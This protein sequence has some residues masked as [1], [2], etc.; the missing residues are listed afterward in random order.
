[1]GTHR[2]SRREPPLLIDPAALAALR[3]GEERQRI[4]AELHERCLAWARR[5][6]RRLSPVDHREIVAEALADALPVIL[7][8][9]ADAAAVDRAIRTSLR[10]S[11]SSLLRARG[12][13]AGPGDGPAE[14]ERDF[15]QI[16]AR[17][18]MEHLVD[19]TRA[20][21]GFISIALDLLCDRDHDLL[22]AGYK[23]TE[24]G[25]RLRGA[26]PPA[27]PDA[28]ALAAATRLALRHFSHNLEAVYVAGRS[29]LAMDPALLDEALRLVRGEA[30]SA[31]GL[32]QALPG[33]T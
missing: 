21:G 28:E 3:G 29:A 2:R 9:D 11:K 16:T 25:L 12:Q 27:F 30:T 15:N 33:R 19:V 1:M 22:I 5:S 32:I 14:L 6:G 18:E 13:R 23:L 24:A 8:R 26:R 17:I 20:A 7:R 31:L 10:R 4:F